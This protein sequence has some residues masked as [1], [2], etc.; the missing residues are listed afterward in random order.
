MQPH[1]SKTFKDGR[2][3]L[4][5]TGGRLPL[6]AGLL[7]LVLV[8]L[9]LGQANDP[10]IASVG[11]R[12]V[13][14]RDL[15]YRIFEARLYEEELWSVPEER[16]R[17]EVLTNAVDDLVLEDYFWQH[18][19]E[20]AP[21]DVKTTVEEIWQRYVRLAG[22][23]AMLD[24]MLDDM[25]IEPAQ[26]KRWMEERLARSWRIRAGL[27]KGLDVPDLEVAEES[28]AS[29]DNFHVAHIFV[30]PQTDSA[31]G[32]EDARQRATRVWFAIT[33]GLPFDRAASLYSDDQESAGRGG[34][35]GWIE[36]KSLAPS[37]SGAL[38]TM[39]LDEVS[40]PVLGPAGYHLLQLQDF[41]TP[42]REEYYQAIADAERR[43][44]MRLRDRA[45]IRV[46]DGYELRPVEEPSTPVTRTTWEEIMDE[47][48]AE[49][50]GSR[51]N[52]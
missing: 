4:E 7:M 28:P 40:S 13:S 51:S 24:T 26:M 43:L 11:Q 3:L 18:T 17:Q 2:R 29:A 41:E 5:W 8:G 47:F 38:R 39:S 23:P 32:W 9:A 33:D 19:P 22:S 21:E 36:A 10:V 46:A 49:V 50:K 25:D 31:R 45:E 35:L 44:L 30:E 20:P 34:D 42:R 1:C 14:A 37:L 52:E 48:R 27:M 6:L 15:K 16:L 12:I